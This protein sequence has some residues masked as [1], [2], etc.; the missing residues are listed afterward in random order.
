MANTGP[1]TS[2]P[3]TLPFTPGQGPFPVVRCYHTTD[4]ATNPSPVWV[5]RTP[6]MRFYST[7]RGRQNELSEFE[8][9]TA[10][11]VFDNRDRAL[12]P[13]INS[14]IR[15]FNRIWL[16]ED[17]SNETRDLFKGYAESWQQGWAPG[18]TADA[19]STV[20]A[21]DEFKPLNLNKLSVTDPPRDTYQDVILFDNPAGYWRM[22][23]PDGSLTEDPAVGNLTL[24]AF[25]GG[26]STTPFAAIVGDPLATA[27]SC[28]AGIGVTPN[29]AGA[30][31]GDAGDA[32]GLSAFTIECWVNSGVIESKILVMGPLP[33]AGSRQ[34]IIRINADGTVT[35][36]VQTTVSNYAANGTSVLAANQWYHLAAI[37][38]SNALTLYI[39]GAQAATVVTSGTVQTG[40]FAGSGNGIT[41]QNAGTG[42]LYFDELAFYRYALAPARMLAHYQAGALRGFPQQSADARIGAVLNAIGSGIT[43]RL[44]TAVRSVQARFMKGQAPLDALRE[45]LE[46]ENVDAAFFISPSSTLNAWGTLVFLPA[47]HRSSAPY[48]TVQATFDDDGTDLPYLDASLDFS[49]S[50]LFNEWNVTREGGSVQTANDSTSIGRYF[51]R[52][53]S[54][55]G[56]ACV[57]DS[58]AA[59][60]SAAQ[61]AKYKDPFTRVTT[62]KP[63]M[64]DPET[65]R[66]V[67]ARDLM[68]RIEFFR[69]PPGGGARIDQV[70]F[71]QKIDISGTPGVPPD[72]TLGVSPL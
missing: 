55:T 57:S 45:A 60:I 19:T 46:A 58:D 15:P 18:G 35:A 12:D 42:T 44:G 50:F 17:Y 64:A 54:L 5:D 49:E 13:V 53:Q 30:V 6:K 25:G 3:L 43:R 1:S 62:I 65:A 27:L 38:G 23:N 29:T 28:S 22:D 39:N 66:V 16:F 26:V 24:A 34:Y 59:T 10:S 67:F 8:A 9:G 36:S 71:I 32:A 21:A 52:S 7:S 2:L 47:N 40:Y 11:V 33:G 56:L 61:L 68:D 69:T 70:L 14:A 4:D 41:V 48:S 31:Q 20:S 51:K 72:V 63:K 37:F